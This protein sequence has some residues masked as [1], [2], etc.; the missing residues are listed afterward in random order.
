VPANIPASLTPLIIPQDNFYPAG[1][2]RQDLNNFGPRLGLVYNL[3]DR[4]VVRSGFGL[5]FDNLNLNE[6]QFTRLVPPFT[7][8]FNLS[9]AG[10]ALVNVADLFPDPQ[11][12]TSFPTPFAMDPNNVTAYVRQWNVN[13]QRTFGRSV[14]F[15]VAYTGS[16]SRHEHKRYNLNQPREGTT[17]QSERLA[18]PQFAPAILTSSDTGHG[19]FKGLSFRLDRRF[20]QGLFFTGSYQLSKNMDNNSGEIEAN[21]TAF[22]WDPEADWALSRYD[23]RQRGAITFGYE[24]PWGEGKPWL[25]RGGA[26]QYLLGNWQISG[27]VRIQSGIPFTVS[28]SSLQPLGSFVP[29]RADFAPGRAD[30]K[31]K[32]DNPTPERWFDSSAYAV[33]AAGFQGRAGRN[34]LIGPGFSRTDIS[35][36]RRFVLAADKHLEFRGEVYNLF[37]RAN[38]GTPASNISNPNVGVIT[39]ADDPRNVQLGI[40][41]AW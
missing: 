6:L 18:Y 9:P 20:S 35:V 22:A 26:M 14:L 32:L 19:D 33:P 30:D 5:Y 10:T 11:L 25:N 4:T 2:V 23:R 12:V 7:G 39:T 27:A 3:N 28:V 15:E 38:F 8:M 41:M 24:L 21:D 37:N 16:Q 1:I 36:S 17:P 29:A 40:R 34:T 13:V 31:G